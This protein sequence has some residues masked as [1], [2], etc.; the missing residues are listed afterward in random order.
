MI[1]QLFAICIDF[2][3]YFC[4]KFDYLHLHFV[5]KCG[6]GYAFRK[7]KYEKSIFWL[8]VKQGCCEAKNRYIPLFMGHLGNKKYI[9]SNL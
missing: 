3:L 4:L 6:L 9:Q 7:V 2:G 5:A 8:F 1:A